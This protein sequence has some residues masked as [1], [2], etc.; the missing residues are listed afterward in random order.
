[1]K[2]ISFQVEPGEIQALLGGNGCGK[3]TTIKILA[4]VVGGDAG[5][6]RVGEKEIDA[7]HVAPSQARALGLRFVHQ[8]PAV[9]PMQSVAENIAL[10]YEFPR[11]PLGTIRWRQV[12]K[13]AQE[14]ADRFELDLDVTQPTATLRPANQA[15][16]AIVRALQDLDE[17]HRAVLVLDEPTA[18]LPNEEVST[19]L[20]AVK[21]YASQG[22]AVLF[23]THRLEEVLEIAHSATVM[24]D[25]LITS[26]LGQ[27]EITHDSL[28]EGI[29]G[30][31]VDRTR[32]R[33]NRA[34]LEGEPLVSVKG[35]SGGRLSDVS[36]ELR[37]G[38]IVG[39]AGLLG[40]GRSSLL[41]TL[42]GLTPWSEGEVVLDGESVRFG[43]PKEAIRSGIAYVPEDRAKDA[44]FNRM[45]VNEN[46]SMVTT[47]EYWRAGWM[48]GREE[49]RDTQ[50]L[51]E[52]FGIKAPG[53]AAAIGAL[54]G[55]NQQKVM[56]VRWIRKPLKLLLLDEPTQGVDVGAR[57]EIFDAINQAAAEGTSVLM[58]SSE[59]EELTLVC[60]RILVMRGGRL[61]SEVLDPSSD[62]LELER[63]VHRKGEGDEATN[64]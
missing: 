28:V 64:D 24:R 57:T 38:E 32:S 30:S 46:I 48:R 44:V 6:I 23:V 1:M 11:G 10:G 5:R 62:V 22:L 34:S 59:Y 37:K 42:F 18:A 19:L 2:G 26:V 55:G 43:G 4:G 36:F 41:R 47:G 52:R 31:T 14:I 40:S 12:R 58:V 7:R 13:R 54:S 45:S 39:I 53:D 16:V 51:M 20:D 63:A 27:D 56:I 50:G 21:K 33:Q 15:M 61:V 9:F 35:I 25:G 29:V 49:K 17:L 60:S 3:S 8:Q